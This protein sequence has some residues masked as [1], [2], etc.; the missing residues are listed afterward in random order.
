[1]MRLS[2]LIFSIVFCF[3]NYSQA[4][5]INKLSENVSFYSSFPALDI[6]K[7]S[8]TILDYPDGK[9][10]TYKNFEVRSKDFYSHYQF[11]NEN[12]DGELTVYKV[13]GRAM[14]FLQNDFSRD[15]DTLFIALDTVY[16]DC[17]IYI[18]RE[19]NVGGIAVPQW[20]NDTLS[21]V[22]IDHQIV[23]IVA[24]LEVGQNRNLVFRENII[25]DK[26]TTI[27]VS[28]NEAVH[29]IIFNPVNENGVLLESAGGLYQR[30]YTLIFDMANGGT[31]LVG[32]SS[33]YKDFFIS[34]FLG[35]I[36]LY[37]SARSTIHS[38]GHSS[39]LI[40]FPKPDSITSSIVLANDPGELVHSISQYS[41]FTPGESNLIGFGCLNKML[42]VSGDYVIVGFIGFYD[43]LS[44][45]YWE[46]HLYM[47]MQDSE[48]FGKCMRYY[49]KIDDEYH[50]MSPHFDEYNTYMAGFRTFVPDADVH[51]INNGDSLFF[52]N[53]LCYYWPIWSNL[54][55]RIR[56]ISDK[57]DM[58]GGNFMEDFKSDKYTIKNEQGLLIA[59]GS[60]LEFQ[61]DDLDLEK[62]TVELSNSACHFDSIVGSSTLIAKID[63]TKTDPNPPPIRQ[64]RLTTGDN[65]IKYRFELGEDVL[66]YFSAA[67][68]LGYNDN[69]IGFGFQSV[70]DSLTKVFIKPNDEHNWTNIYCR[71]IYMDSIVGIQY[72]ANLSDYLAGE[73][74]LYDIKIY[75]EDFSGNSSEY[76]FNPAFIYGD[77]ITG[78]DENTG[79]PL[80]DQGVSFLPNP[81][82]NQI[83]ISNIGSY[84]VAGLSYKIVD[85]LGHD[86]KKGDLP[87]NTSINIA[88]LQAGLYFIVLY[89][90]NNMLGSSKLLKIQ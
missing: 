61:V 60:G 64:I 70:V 49:L 84:D 62:Y 73:P 2:I 7:V 3:S 38:S 9:S 53:G 42:W 28:A 17:S 75:V 18:D 20:L 50:F 90:R 46:T 30:G 65:T 51:Y 6:Q 16:D 24:I 85:K 58:W 88:D 86:V 39:Y 32:C 54:S 40:E 12:E 66:L 87:Q 71:N 69:H 22:V 79:N 4:Q 78:L 29:S 19:N 14:P 33:N 81:A 5:H 47:D 37:F 67:D 45:P 43:I 34:D 41:L 31:A 57:M 11:D 80:L 1:M 82:Y 48:H 15:T 35:E 63:K 76:T 56:C 55:N 68:F 27:S 52:G 8:D 74:T 10:I 83:T 36:N 25:F 21:F 72:M 13:S 26:Q 59:E 89:E 23:N 77:Y 44:G